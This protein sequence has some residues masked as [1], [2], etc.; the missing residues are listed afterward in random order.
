MIILIPPS[1]GKNRIKKPLDTKFKDTE[2]RLMEDVERVIRLLDLISVED[3]RSIYGT[4]QE[5]ALSFHRQNQDAMNSRCWYA[6]ER[7]TGVVYENLEWGTL[8]KRAKNYM[9]KNVRI[10][11]GLFGLLTPK[12]LIP[13]YKLKMNVLSLQYH[14]NPI[15]TEELENEDLIIDLLPQVHRKAYNSSKKVLEIEFLVTSTGETSTA[16]HYGKAVKG[17]FIRYLALNQIKSIDEFEG[18]SYDGFNWD[19]K[20]FIKEK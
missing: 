20:A 7:Y 9:E 14:W 1:E 12:T 8:P 5:K 6:V 13:E 17:K 3:L 16:G 15:L 11:S 2:F 10:I 18:F 19:G 4:S